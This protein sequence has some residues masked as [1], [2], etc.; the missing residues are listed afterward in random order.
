MEVVIFDSESN[1]HTE[2]LEFT[3]TFTLDCSYNRI[4]NYNAY[5]PITYTIGSGF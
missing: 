3:I 5:E 1:D 2:H 4:T